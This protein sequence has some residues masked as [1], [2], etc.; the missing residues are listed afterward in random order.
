[1]PTFIVI[2]AGK[3]VD[4]MKGADPNGLSRLV[5][6]YAGPN[7]PIQPLPEGAEEARAAGNVRAQYNC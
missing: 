6:H 5:S 3:Q 7:P 1:M 4:V 2:K